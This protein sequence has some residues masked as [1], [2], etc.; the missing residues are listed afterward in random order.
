MKNA[1]MI[2]ILKSMYWQCTYKYGSRILKLVKEAYEIDQQSGNKLWTES[3][4][5]DMNKA[6]VAH[7]TRCL[8]A[9]YIRSFD[10]YLGENF[11]RKARTVPGSHTTFTYV[12]V[13]GFLRL[14]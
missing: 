5:K 7:F 9:V 10:L 4:R 6:R 13:C 1:V 11:Q 2:S 14:R 3:I 12:H 8:M